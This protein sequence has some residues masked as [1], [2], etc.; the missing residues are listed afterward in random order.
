MEKLV[1]TFIICLVSVL[2]LI[3]CSHHPEPDKTDNSTTTENTTIP[4]EKILIRS[5]DSTRYSVFPST[6][7]SM[8]SF[9]D[10]RYYYYVF[11]LGTVKYVPLQHSFDT[12]EFIGNE[13]TQ[14]FTK[15][16]SF[17]TITIEK[18][19]ETL[20][21]TNTW[22]QTLSTEL[23]NELS[24]SV[25]IHNI[26]LENRTT[27]TAG[28]EEIFGETMS[29]TISTQSTKI[30]EFYESYEI[31]TKINFNKNFPSGFYRYILMTDIEYY[32][33]VT[34]DTR[35]KELT[36]SN[37]PLLGNPYFSLDFSDNSY[38]KAAHSDELKFP[39]SWIKNNDIPNQIPDIEIIPENT[40]YI[41]TVTDL[42][43]LRSPNKQNYIFKLTNN[44]DGKNMYWSPISDFTGTLMGNGYS[45]SNLQIN[46]HSSLDSDSFNSGFINKNNGIIKDICFKNI[47]LDI[48]ATD[49]TDDFR[50]LNV[51]TV[52][53]INLGT[54]EDVHLENITINSKLNHKKD[55]SKS[56]KQ[57]NTTGG[58]IGTNQGSISYCSIRNSTIS[59]STDA[60]KNY[61]DTSTYV[62]GI[63]GEHAEKGKASNLLTMYTTVSANS[64]GGFWGG[65]G[66][67]DGSLTS[68]SG[69]IFGIAN[70]YSEKIIS[71]NNK[72]PISTATVAHD[73]PSIDKKIGDIIGNSAKSITYAFSNS[74][75]TLIGNDENLG[76]KLSNFNIE[77]F[78][79]N[80][81]WKY[82]TFPSSEN[83]F[84][85]ENYIE[86]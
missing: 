14:E 37:A 22:Q 45:I 54:I 76:L 38:F 10:D 55:Q 28:F 75:G 3:S 60:K 70:A 57:K 52:A 29:H 15:K 56:P 35:K 61:C 63:C 19:S 9:K 50:Q 67:N 65:F 44:I 66:K 31:K 27:V 68:Y 1:N 77:T 7:S 12:F 82:W 4:D 36:L 59:A 51:G 24:L 86:K 18:V 16:K 71:Y 47:T 80:Q 41:K 43:Q 42:E 49:Y 20:T 40:C 39:T 69:N 83:N 84:E 30:K 74:T 17:E 58:I 32:G 11:Y 6:D 72:T 79:D 62:G 25:G 46:S 13:L 5:N 48:S 78:K 81:E 34:Y 26:N 33:I 73:N 8:Y 64:R 85:L 2:F 21:Q 53:A 23:Q